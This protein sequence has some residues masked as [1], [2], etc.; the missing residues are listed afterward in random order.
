MRRST[1]E[2]YNPHDP[3]NDASLTARWEFFK[4]TVRQRPCTL[5]IHLS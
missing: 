2:L 3:K 5:G 4:A 1:A